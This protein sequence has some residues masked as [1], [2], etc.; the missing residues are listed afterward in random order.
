VSAI[1]KSIQR[2]IDDTIET[3]QQ[4]NSLGLAAPQAGLPLRLI[5]SQMPDGQPMAII[6][7]EI[8]KRT[9]EQEV[10]ESCLSI[11]GYSVEIKRLA[12]VTVKGIDRRGKRIKIKVSGLMVEALEHEI[13]QLDRVLYINYVESQDKLHQVDHGRVTKS[14]IAEAGCKPSGSYEYPGRIRYLPASQDYE[15]SNRFCLG[16]FADQPHA[17]YILS[18]KI[19]VGAK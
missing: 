12:Q 17:D 6:N 11:P 18:G 9:G 10:T 4:A 2:I 16:S 14:D 19:S 5:I 13:D 8:V 7:P 3:M 1:D 15:E